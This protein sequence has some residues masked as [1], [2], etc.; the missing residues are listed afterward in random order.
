M[1]SVIK[2]FLVFATIIITGLAVSSCK[3]KEYQ[4][5][6]VYPAP[7]EITAAQG[8]DCFLVLQ[9]EIPGRSHI[10]GN[11][12]GPGTGKPTEVTVQ[13][14][15]GIAVGTPRFLQPEKFYFLGDSQ[16]T[17]GYSGETRI[18]V[19]FTVREAAT[20][21]P[22]TLAV[23]FD[24]LMC[25]EGAGGAGS[26]VPKIFHFD[27]PL[28][29]VKK[30]STAC[31][32]DESILSEYA[33]SKAPVDGEKNSSA[34]TIGAV[35]DPSSAALEG[36]KFSPRYIEK[37]ITGLVQAILFGLIAGIIL[38]FMPCVL[39]VVSLKVM[40]FVQHANES[41][42]KLL[43]LGLFFA[44]GILA[45]FALLASLA[46]FFGYAW[47]GL[48]QHRMFLV[49]MT[50]IVFAFALS[51]F[52]VFSI[53]TPFFVGRSVKDRGNPYIDAFVK[54]LLATLLATPCSGPFLGGTLAWTLSQPPAAIIAVFMSI[55]T[56]MA[57]PYVLLTALPKLLKYIPKPGEWLHVFEQ[58][59]GFLLMFT[60]IYLA[61]I[62]SQDSVLPMVAF[63]GFIAIGLWQYGRYGSLHRVALTRALSTVAMAII[64]VAGYF[65]SFHYLYVKSE[66]PGIT[67]H[68]FSVE[69]MI[70][71]RDSGRISVID[72]TAEWCPNCK[73]VES[74]TLRDRNVVSSLREGD[75]DFMVADIT[76]K[77]PAAECLMAQFRSQSIPL[78]A[79]IPPGPSFGEPVILRDIYSVDDVLAALKMARLHDGR[80]GQAEYQLE[81]PDSLIQK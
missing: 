45:S 76:T 3:Q 15:A 46:A 32:H 61:G 29:V 55:G 52:G 51:L 22:V 77:H 63:L 79:V 57:F 28:L 78:L 49:V 73:L 72:F 81:V 80:R 16:F 70:R 35:Q 40:N 44:F 10:Y 54:G 68:S 26:C 5:M 41:R 2:R 56:G 65:I 67:G 64:I 1:N 18:F 30:G 4:E 34:G 21:G 38:N 59:M 14:P 48:F 50:G 39:P 25:T 71:N 69:R 13:S 75:V 20:P 31:G 42:K 62:L 74:M 60:V 47:G 58:A 9:V 11:P 43:I 36:L 24:S 17:W 33:L 27:V 53:N 23:T 37:G 6:K 19:P 7:R 66:T 8:S 12:K